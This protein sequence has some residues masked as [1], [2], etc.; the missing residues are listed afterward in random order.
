MSELYVFLNGQPTRADFKLW[1]DAI[2]NITSGKEMLSTTIGEYLR[3]PHLSMDWTMNGWDTALYQYWVQDFEVMYDVFLSISDEMVT[4][5]VCI[6][7]WSMTCLGKPPR[8]H[9]AMVC[10]MD[11][12]ELVEL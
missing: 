3:K 4:R 9:Y 12:I 1:E 2:I 5:N 10:W 11:C 7:V 8:T 6:F